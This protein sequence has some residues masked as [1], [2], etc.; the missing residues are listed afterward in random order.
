MPATYTDYLN[1]WSTECPEK[2]W[3]RELGENGNQDWNWLEAH[4]EI[5]AL[6]SWL[7]SHL[8]GAG[9]RVGLLSKNRAHWYFADFGSIAA[10]HVVVPMFTTLAGETADYVMSFTDMKL[11][12][13]GE[14]ENWD[15]IK[16]VLP[17]GIQLV[18]LP[19]VELE[20]D[21]LRWEDVVAPHRGSSPSYQCKSDDLVSLVFTSGT[22]G[23]PK[24]VMQTHDS[25]IVPVNRFSDA[26][27][28]PRGARYFSYLPLSHIAER[29]I[30]EGASLVNCGEVHFNENLGTLLRDLP[31]CRPQ[32]MFGPPRVWEQ[33]QQGV[34]AQFGSPDAV[35]AAL[36]A[37]SEGIGKLVRDKL[38]L[39]EAEYL[40]TAAAPTPPALIEWYDRFG[41]NLMEGF[42]QTECMGPIVS[43]ADNRRIGS[44]GKAMPGVEVKI[45]DE[46][47][48]L[49]KADGCSPG[50]YNMPEKTA[51]TFV[52]GWVHT[53]D[54]VK[55]DDDGFYYITGRVKDYFKTIQGKF[56]APTPIENIFAENQHTEQICLLGRGYSK[57]VMTCV[58]T[59]MAQELPREDIE[60]ALR[61]R[62]DAVNKETEHH[63]RIGAVMVS[64]NPWTIENGVLT[65]TLKIRREKVEE[66]FGE[67]AAVLARQ[68]AEQGKILLEWA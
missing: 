32:M 55:V 60:A 40:L 57:T 26:F 23:V 65:P 21:H 49:V 30:V 6:G 45:S 31:Q 36:E 22:T 20:E 61:E 58:L 63:A 54:K 3:L 13:V 50:Y 64:N 17:G 2:M 37:D 42:G 67:Q 59:A 62:V 33:I 18:C 48:L 52:D 8:D 44:V 1:K 28:I 25:N 29:Q 10:G 12:F 14:T 51:E 38:G 9:Q 53:G 43:S 34:I 15:Q 7:E 47:E 5:N 39:D 16:A 35:D 11:L 27:S 4:Q 46:D 41:I 56:V 24:G 68:A 19:G 66:L